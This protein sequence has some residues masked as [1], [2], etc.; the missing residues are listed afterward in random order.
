MDGRWY[1]TKSFGYE[2]LFLCNID[3]WKTPEE[4]FNENI[5]E[6][7]PINPTT[8]LPAKEDDSWV[9]EDGT[10]YMLISSC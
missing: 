6:E 5:K 2:E 1:I 7:I 9:S 3:Y 4:L 8:G 10:I